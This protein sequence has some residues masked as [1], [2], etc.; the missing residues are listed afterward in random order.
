[1]IKAGS[2]AGYQRLSSNLRAC[3]SFLGTIPPILK[4]NETTRVAPASTEHLK[5]RLYQFDPRR[6][7][8]PAPLNDVLDVI[9][10]A[11]PLGRIA[12]RDAVLG[13]EL[14]IANASDVQRLARR[15]SGESLA[16]ICAVRGSS[17]EFGRNF[18]LIFENGLELG[19][20]L[21]PFG[22]DA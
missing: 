1:M 10:P 12:S 7:A 11:G 16:T 22:L 20:V 19:A 2:G 13:F 8:A 14:S 5:S 17:P 6:N 15:S 9:P 4:V 18:W 3:H 21:E